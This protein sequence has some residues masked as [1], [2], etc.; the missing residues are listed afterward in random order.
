MA[1]STKDIMLRLAF[2]ESEFE[3]RTSRGSGRGC[4]CLGGLFLVE[5]WMRTEYL[6]ELFPFL[7]NTL[8]SKSDLFAD[9]INLDQSH[10]DLVVWGW[11]VVESVER[12]VVG[13]GWWVLVSG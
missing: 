8:T 7:F 10:R 6:W 12:V 4:D 9:K 5:I 1:P 3:K 2:R 11:M 13:R